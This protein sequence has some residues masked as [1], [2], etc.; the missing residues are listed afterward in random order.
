[1]S[2]E[3]TRLSLESSDIHVGP[4][5][6][7]NFFSF[8]SDNCTPNIY[9]TVAPGFSLFNDFPKHINRSAP[10]V[11]MKGAEYFARQNDADMYCYEILSFNELPIS[12]LA[13]LQI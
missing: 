11:H 3:K 12:G 4:Q 9:S 13:E 5:N 6:S 2:E 7:S 1:M 10:A 8:D